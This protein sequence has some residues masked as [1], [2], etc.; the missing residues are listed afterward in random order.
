MN[1]T[2]RL[3]LMVKHGWSILEGENWFIVLSRTGRPV[4]KWRTFRGAI[5]V[6]AAIVER[7]NERYA[8]NAA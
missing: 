1:D 3:L 5:D 6:A 7:E 8:E 2:D 4:A